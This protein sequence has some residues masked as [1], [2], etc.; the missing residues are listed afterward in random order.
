M[1]APPQVHL[2]VPFEIEWGLDCPA[3]DLATVSVA[4]VGSEIAR[5]RISAR[6]GIS[7]MSEASVFFDLVIARAIPEAGL[8]VAYGR[9]HVVVPAGTGTVPSLL[10]RYNAIGWAIVVEAEFRPPDAPRLSE[11]FSIVVLPGEP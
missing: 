1:V 11:S 6:T 3:G 7:V 9:A 4:L 5:Q 8:R 2:G 10:G